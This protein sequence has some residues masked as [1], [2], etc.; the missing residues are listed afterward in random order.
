M[1][2]LWT[3]TEMVSTGNF[4]KKDPLEMFLFM[5]MLKWD[6][7]FWVICTELSCHLF[8]FISQ[9]YWMRR[10][11]APMCTMSTRETQIWTEWET[12][13][14]IALWNI[15]L[16]RCV[17]THIHTTLPHFLP[18]QPPTIIHIHPLAFLYSSAYICLSI[19]TEPQWLALYSCLTFIMPCKGGVNPVCS[20]R[21][22]QF[23]KAWWGARGL[24]N[25]PLTLAG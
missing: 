24:F 8:L 25:G 16:I 13:A 22:H 19:E 12:C 18:L 21:A 15:I 1:H 4:N 17:D 11:T 2:A 14:T 6:H 10:T 7:T 5:S 9:A 20:S 3:S 23:N